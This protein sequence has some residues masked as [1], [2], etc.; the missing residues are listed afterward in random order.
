[1]S[2]T[3]R[4]KGSNPSP[5]MA[6]VKIDGEG[7]DEWGDRYF[8][9][10]VKG[11]DRDIPPFSAKQL[12]L[13]G[14][15]PLFAALVDAGWN[16]FTPRAQA[17]LLQQLQARK[18]EAPS[19]KVVTRLGWNSGAYV[20]PDET[21]GDPKMPLEKAFSG[22]DSAMRGKYRVKGTR[23]EW[24]DQ[25]ASPCVGKLPSNVCC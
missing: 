24:Q 14:P 1:M 2:K 13:E 23:E 3:S 11:S 8:K 12:L 10:S 22:L 25:I 7:L 20:F 17:A 4:P 16:A 15:K 5:A 18:K 21:I 6:H 9:F 19:F